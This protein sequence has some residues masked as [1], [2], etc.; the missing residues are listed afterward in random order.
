[1][2]KAPLEQFQILSLLNVSFLNL[3]FSLTN[4]LLINLLALTIFSSL[5]YFNSLKIANGGGFQETTDYFHSNAWQKVLDIISETAAQL[6]SDIIATDNQKYVPVVFV[7]FNFILFSNLIGLVP[8]TFTATSHVIVTFTLSFSIFIGITIS[9][10]EKYKM[11]GFSLFLPANSSFLLALILVP[12]EF[13]SYIA[14]PISL[15]MRLFINLM[16][17]HSLLKVIIGFAW[18]MLLLE[19][20][21][22]FGLVIPMVIV[23]VLFGLE[24]GVAL[25]QT[26]VFII[27]TCIYIQD[28]S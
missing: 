6:I 3:D 20:L 1:M 17:G 16:A 27:L 23:V 19:N 26:Y 28:G 8:Y 13:I 10:F 5:F 25:I 7:T 4:F 12:I 11:Q 2:L 18:S 24:L 14:R 9:T 15:G 22:S 21:T